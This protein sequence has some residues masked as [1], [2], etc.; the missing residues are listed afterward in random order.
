M[1]WPGLVHADAFMPATGDAVRTVLSG[2][3][4]LDPI[5]NNT[6]SKVMGET[7]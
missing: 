6:K 1:S 2:E 4:G 5:V 3:A 7:T